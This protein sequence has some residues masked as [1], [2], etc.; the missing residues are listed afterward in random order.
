[1][2]HD[3]VTVLPAR[4]PRRAPARRIASLT[5]VLALALAGLTAAVTPA[6][7]SFPGTNGKIYYSDDVSGNRDIYA[8]N[9][10]GTGATQITDTADDDS[11]PAS[12]PDGSKIVFNRFTD[13]QGVYT[14]NADGTGVTQVGSGNF[15]DRSSFSGD[16]TKIVYPAFDSGLVVVNADGTGATVLGT[17]TNANSPA[18]SPDGTRIAFTLSGNIFTV[19]PDGTGTTQLTTNPPGTLAGAPN[20][21]PDS[22]RIAYNQRAGMGAGQV[23]VMNADGTGQTNI[24]ND[25]ITSNAPLWAPDGTKIAFTRG[26]ALWTMNPD[27][28]G[29]TSVLAAGTGSRNFTNW[30]AGP[31]PANA[32]IA[33]SLTAQPHLGIL[34]PY[35]SYTVTAHNNGPG[36]VTSATLTAT[37]PAG[38]TATNPSPGCTSAPGSVTCTYGAIANGAS[39]VSTFR[40]PIGL[41]TIGQVTVTATRTASAPTDNNAAN[42]H[43]SRTCTV[44][45]II[46]ATCP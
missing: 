7:A 43:A 3:T 31:P 26:G 24:S 4:G 6:H 25:A 36:A 37:L 46:L 23:Y 39:A 2:P 17:N 32:D 22:T 41:L 15:D 18:W 8:V 29:K 28:T 42:D 12:S 9:P 30:A 16:G 14:M 45:S 19:H 11:N 35:L 33:V 21:S 5:A 1:M 44:V 13:G 38:K 34:V 27:G 40:L 10:D 20:W